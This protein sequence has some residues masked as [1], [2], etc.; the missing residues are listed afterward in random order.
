MSNPQEDDEKQRDDILQRMLKTPPKPHKTDTGPKP[1]AH[2]SE[3]ETDE[4]R[5]SPKACS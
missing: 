3:E 4:E 1:D 2:G 5:N